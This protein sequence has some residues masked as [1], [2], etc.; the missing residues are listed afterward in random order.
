[1]YVRKKKKETKTTKKTENPPGLFEGGQRP[2][3]PPTPGRFHRLGYDFGEPR[4]QAVSSFLGAKG[5][6][7]ASKVFLG[8]LL[9]F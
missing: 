2:H 1:M 8:F 7:S 3:F 9:F 4:I 5:G 6:V